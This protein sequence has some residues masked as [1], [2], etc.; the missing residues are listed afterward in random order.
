MKHHG[1]AS[2]L[3]IFS[4]F[5]PDPNSIDFNKSYQDE[6]NKL[7]I[8]PRSLANN[9]KFL[10]FW[11]R[12]WVSNNH[13]PSPNTAWTS[14]TS[15]E[16][17]HCHVMTSYLCEVLTYTCNVPTMNHH[18]EPSSGETNQE[19]STPFVNEQYVGPS[20]PEHHCA[21]TPQHLDRPCN[22]SDPIST[23]IVWMIQV[24]WMPQLII[25][26]NWI[27]PALH[28]NYKTSLVLKLSLFLSLKKHLENAQ[29]SQTD[30]FLNM[31]T[32]CS[33]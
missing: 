31:T 8:L 1:V 9:L 20:I 23:L 18:Q 14:L 12:E 29:L 5:Y 26:L 10:C 33:Y 2:N 4:N 24:H 22:L 21:E 3:H 17:Q 19:D 27:L 30:F 32:N 25:C 15:E 13:I 6:E 11:D 28:F 7:G 16:F